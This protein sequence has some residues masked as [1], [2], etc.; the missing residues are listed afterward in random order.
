M[1][2]LDRSLMA[3]GDQPGRALAIRQLPATPRV[4][5]QDRRAMTATPV[6]IPTDLSEFAGDLL[7]GGPVGADLLDNLFG[8]L[9]SFGS[10]LG[11]SVL[12]ALGQTQ[13]MF[14]GVATLPFDP[15]GGGQ[16]I[17]SA[18]A[19]PFQAVD[20]KTRGQ[21][22]AIQFPAVTGGAPM[23][24]QGVAG[25][26]IDNLQVGMQAPSMGT[27]TKVWD[28]WPG[29][30]VTGGGRAP[31]FFR[32]IDGKTFVRKIDGTI[33]KVPKSRNLVLNTRKINLN[34]FIKMDRAIERIASRIAKKSKRL[35]RS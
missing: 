29:A 11:E 4:R 30:G 18:L 16:Q 8:R 33:K 1:V 17:A 15:I 22:P 9:G 31:I 25:Q 10:L 35:K 26:S 12:G 14:Q 6:P 32:T 34:T 13:R 21:A 19:E 3:G 20:K 27:I 2:N 7:I 5:H 24:Q 28:T 23:M